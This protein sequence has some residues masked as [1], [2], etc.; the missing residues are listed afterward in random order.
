MLIDDGVNADTLEHAVIVRTDSGRL[1]RRGPSRSRRGKRNARVILYRKEGGAYQK[2]DDSFI[3]FPNNDQ[4]KGVAFVGGRLLVSL[5]GGQIKSYDGEGVEK[6]AF[7]TGMGVS[8]WK[9]EV[10]SQ[11][12][13]Y[14]LFVAQR[15]GHRVLS[16]DVAFQ[17]GG[18][19][20]AGAIATSGRASAFPRTWRSRRTSCSFPPRRAS[21]PPS[22]PRT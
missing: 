12:G 4:P 20:I 21:P 22:T 18:D 1:V 9:I 2:H 16:V 15:S 5:V 14:R 7:A 13:T 10:G 6:P 19:P 8:L 3:S 17:S 11:G